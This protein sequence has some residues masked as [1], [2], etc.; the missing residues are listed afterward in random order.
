MGE[1]E[2][3]KFEPTDQNFMDKVI[4]YNLATIRNVIFFIRANKNSQPLSQGLWWFF[5]LIYQ[6]SK[7]KALKGSGNEVAHL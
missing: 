6:I 7:K 1:K 5:F 2:Q 4:L 3:Q